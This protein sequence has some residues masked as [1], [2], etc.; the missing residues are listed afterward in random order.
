MMVEGGL[1]ERLNH[2]STML[3]D[4]KPEWRWKAA[5]ELGRMREPRALSILVRALQDED[6][7]VRQKAAWALGALGDVRAI[8]PLR[9]LMTDPSDGVQDMALLA[10]EA[11]KRKI[12][13]DGVGHD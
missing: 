4:P 8:Q 12:A 2:F 1:E 5:Q 10:I 11:V 6:W 9:R 7:R 3:S 13:D